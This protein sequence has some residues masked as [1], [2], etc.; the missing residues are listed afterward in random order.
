MGKRKREEKRA[1][2]IKREKETKRER[3]KKWVMQEDRGKNES[4]QMIFV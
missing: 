2:E 4:H 1:T 3:G